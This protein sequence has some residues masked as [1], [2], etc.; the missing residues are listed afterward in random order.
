MRLLVAEGAWEFGGGS[1]R[2]RSL[3]KKLLEG[4]GEYRKSSAGEDSRKAQGK[5]PPNPKKR[6][7]EKINLSDS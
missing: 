3:K 5:I 4:F 1:F 6:R 2:S 7:S